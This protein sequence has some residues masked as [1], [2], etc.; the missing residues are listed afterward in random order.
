MTDVTDPV[1][2]EAARAARAFVAAV[3]WGE[4]RR[5]WELLS[6]EG[7]RTVLRV[8]VARGMD[9]ALSARLRDGTATVAELDTFLTDLVNGL[10]ADLAGN[11]LD[12]IECRRDPVAPE[13]GPVWVVLTAPLPEALG[14]DVPVGTMELVEEGGR[15]MVDRLSPRPRS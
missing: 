13:V 14:G 2:D 1:G 9:E 8:A 5:V 12:A 6:Q 11:D 4:H 15:W 10:R 3:A 7:R